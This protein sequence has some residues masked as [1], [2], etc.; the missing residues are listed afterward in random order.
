MKTKN[1]GMNTDKIFL[2]IDI[3]DNMYL[4]LLN[5]DEDLVLGNV[6]FENR[7]EVKKLIERLENLLEAHQ[8]LVEEHR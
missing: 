1:F 3:H 7:D 5:E 6:K 8:N 2:E 4:S